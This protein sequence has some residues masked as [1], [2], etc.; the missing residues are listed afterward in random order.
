MLGVAIERD[1]TRRRL[2]REL[3]KPVGPRVAARQ[4]GQAAEACDKGI[5]AE[6]AQIVQAPR[7]GVEQR[8]DHQGQPR[9]AVITARAR[10]GLTQPREQVDLPQTAL[11]QLEAAVYEVNAWRTNWI[12]RSPLTTRRKLAALKRIGGA[13][14]VRGSA[15][16]CSPLL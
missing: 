4:A 11:Y 5:T 9:A 16:G 14:S 6:L 10:E 7:A 12:V 2:L 1:E 3:A 13:S 8:Q 15:W